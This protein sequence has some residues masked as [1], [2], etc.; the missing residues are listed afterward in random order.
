ML[1]IMSKEEKGISRV[2][3]L[4]WAAVFCS[5]FFFYL[6]TVIIRWSWDFTDLEPSFFAFS[7]FL[8]GFF[9]VLII[10]VLR[11][12]RIQPNNYHYLFGRMATNCIAVFCFYKAVETGTVAEANILNMT[13]PLFVTLFS[14]FF[15][16]KQ[17]DVVAVWIVG[18]AFFGVWL[19]LA[20]LDLSAKTGNIWGLCSGIMAAFAMLYLNVSRKFHDSQTILFFMFGFGA[21]AMYLAYYDSIYL[22]SKQEMFFLFCCAITGVIGQY[23]I[24]YGF[25]FVTAVEGSIISSSRILLAAML[26][27]VMVGDPALTMTGWF[28]ALLIFIAN[29]ML[30]V[31][32]SHVSAK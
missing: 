20:P 6:S 29:S 31:R 15:M 23:L 24:T 26:G 11:K 16:K 14:W 12:Q 10:M 13:Y 22:P 7:R 19:V 3:L 30:A 17:R 27:P 2:H 28:G 21:L 32:R 5:A 1:R 8:L 9:I 25:L 18:L 4:G